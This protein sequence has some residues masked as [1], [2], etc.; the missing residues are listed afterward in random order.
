MVLH[1]RPWIRHANT[2]GILKVWNAVYTVK[3]SESEESP[4]AIIAEFVGDIGRAVKK[5]WPRLNKV[6]GFTAAHMIIGALEQAKHKVLN[7]LDN[8]LL[9]TLEEKYFGPEELDER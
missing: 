3:M 9:E 8:M 6:S 2:G 4:E 7:E 1:D 5:H